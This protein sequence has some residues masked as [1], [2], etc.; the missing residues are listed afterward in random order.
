MDEQRMQEPASE[1]YYHKKLV[2]PEHV[3]INR[4]Y[5]FA[6]VSPK[7]VTDGH[8]LVCPKRS[9]QSLA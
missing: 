4:K 6:M 8:V 3:F 9:V 5:V 7:P 2:P 1:F